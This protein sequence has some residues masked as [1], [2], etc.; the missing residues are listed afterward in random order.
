MNKKY[1]RIKIYFFSGIL[2]T[3]L[4]FLISLK[5]NN[6]SK[7]TPLF[8]AGSGR[9]GS[10]LLACILNNHPK[11]CIPVEH[12]IIPTIIKY[13]QLHPLKNWK[14]KVSGIVKLLEA[15]NYWKINIKEIQE[16]LV[17]AN[18]KQQTPEFIIE[19]IYL[20]KGESVGKSS[21]IWGDKTPSNTQ[22]IKIMKAQFVNSKILFLVRDPRDYMASMLKMNASNSEIFDFL[23]WRWKNSMDSYSK[24][25]R[26]FPNDIK[27]LSYES[28]VKN[29]LHEITQ[30][31]HWQNLDVP[32]DILVGYS[33]N[34]TFMHTANLKHHQNILQPINSNSIETWQQVLTENQL[35][36][37]NL[38]VG[39]KMKELGYQI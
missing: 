19:C 14:E 6:R 7:S 34:M 12:S 26:E 8:I 9:N 1:S 37:I 23:L 35:K 13:Y 17:A 28:L 20:Q 4:T 22:F 33:K 3:L 39:E 30:L 15:T 32:N 21:F 24:L 10:T 36:K 11:I 31:L 16:K 27:L 18:K 38:K 2:N 25:K 5:Q 29:P